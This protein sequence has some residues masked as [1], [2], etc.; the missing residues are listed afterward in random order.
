MSYLSAY[1]TVIAIAFIVAILFAVIIC[2]A[3][4]RN[5]LRGFGPE[6][7]NFGKLLAELELKQQKKEELERN[8]QEMNRELLQVEAERKEQ[9]H[10][11]SQLSLL[12]EECLRKEAAIRDVE[13][14]MEEARALA[15]QRDELEAAVSKAGKELEELER[16]RQPLEE[17][18]KTLQQRLAECRSDLA[19]YERDKIRYDAL[20]KEKSSLESDIAQS[21]RDFADQQKQAQEVME[22]L[23][24]RRQPLEEEVK[25]LQQ[26]AGELRSALD[27]YEKDRLRYDE[28]LHAR[29]EAERS[30]AESGRKLEQLEEGI[31][32]LEKRRQPLEEEVKT[33]QQRLSELRADLAEYERDKIRYDALLEEKN[34]LESDIAQRQRD[35]A[36]QQK[37]AQEVMEALEKR[38]QPLE[39][40]VKKLQ[41]QAGELRSALDGYEKDRLRYDELLHAR[42]E[43]ERSVAENDR[44]LKQLMADMEALKPELAS[45][46][47]QAEKSRKEYAEGVQRKAELEVSVQALSAKEAALGNLIRQEEEKMNRLSGKKGT[48]MDRKAVDAAYED[49][50]LVEPGALREEDMK[51]P[52]KQQ[53]EQNR[54]SAFQNYLGKKNLYFS[55][56]VLYAFHTALK[57]QNINPLTV[58]AG[59]SGT[60]KTLLPVNYAEFF[61]MHTLVIPVQPRWDSPQDLFGFYNYLEKK[62]KATDLS[63]C[64]VR[65]D[66]YNYKEKNF[67]WA[68]ERMLLVLLDEMNLA[69]TEYYFSEFLSKLELRRHIGRSNQRSEMARQK[70][71]IVL[72]GGTAGR[73]LKV[74]VPQ[75]VLFVGTMNEDESTQTL[76]DKVLDRSNVLR[77]GKPARVAEATEVGEAVPASEFLPVSTWEAWQKQISPLATYYTPCKDW[78]TKLNDGMEKVGRPFGYRVSEAMLLYVANYPIAADYHLALADQVEQKILPKLR[79]IDIQDS[80]TTECLNIVESVIEEL[81]DKELREAF[82]HARQESGRL[83]LFTWRGVSRA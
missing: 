3:L 60:G 14:Q 22:E 64:L 1:A 81:E 40:E 83:G 68:H 57:C 73:Q 24:K 39:E 19:E 59:V 63:R 29:T 69:R 13:R 26:Q 55:P 21:Q 79:G 50:F 67:S 18:E 71:E 77:F 20:L 9:E 8:I 10:L 46:K 15:E 37:Q 30:V 70:A 47:T 43:A 51:R 66:P 25:K 7:S 75:N 62:Y 44:K 23:E 17:E 58:L 41:Q 72:D 48:D 76:S 42:T 78:I 6:V 52:S 80:A 31:N 49:L 5:W 65:M 56:R 32:T 27:G 28:L 54:L 53:P 82:L 36:D 38:R 4:V 74:W 12:S 61:G 16:R 45:L 11:R 35:F 33:L 2:Y 34:S